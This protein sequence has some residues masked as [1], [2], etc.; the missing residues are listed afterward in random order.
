MGLQSRKGNPG[1]PLSAKRI[2][3]AFRKAG[4][5]E[6]A[7]ALPGEAPLSCSI[8]RDCAPAS[9]PDRPPG[10]EGG[11]LLVQPSEEGNLDGPAVAGGRIRRGA[12]LI[13]PVHLLAAQDQELPVSGSG[14]MRSHPG[15]VP[16]GPPSRPAERRADA[17]DWLGSKVQDQEKRPGRPAPNTRR[18]PSG[19]Q[20]CRVL[21][22]LR[23]WSENPYGLPIY[24]VAMVAA[25]KS[26]L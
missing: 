14:N 2:A 1:S 21:E 9:L 10:V 17:S 19:L 12:V 22:L 6:L 11:F 24:R 7:V 13:Q 26:K 5:R 4:Q 3:H 8:Q 20:A 23:D 16:G 18:R 25:E 15:G